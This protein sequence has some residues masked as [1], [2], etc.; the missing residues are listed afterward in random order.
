M[1]RLFNNKET[2]NDSVD[3]RSNQLGI[4]DTDESFVVLMQKEF[5][6]PN[7]AIKFSITGAFR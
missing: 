6:P 5:N 1:K 2:V 3:I 4:K 7:E